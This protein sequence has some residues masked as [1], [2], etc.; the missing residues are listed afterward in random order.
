MASLG[1]SDSHWTQP[2]IR[3]EGSA[4]GQPWQC[5]RAGVS[6]MQQALDPAA[7]KDSG[8]LLIFPILT[9]DPESTV[10]NRLLA[11]FRPLLKLRKVLPLT[12]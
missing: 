12:D 11:Q 4:S 5:N 7:R 9:P 10:P 2:T 1:T 3:R 6:V 8:P